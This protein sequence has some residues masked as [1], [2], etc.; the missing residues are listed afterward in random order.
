MGINKMLTQ[1]FVLPDNMNFVDVPAFDYGTP[2]LLMTNDFKPKCP[3]AALGDFIVE[4]EEVLLQASD[5]LVEI[6]MGFLKGFVDRN[7]LTT[8]TACLDDI[9]GII[10][11]IE[12]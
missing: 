9:E 2:Q 8:V 7:N 11:T 6:T 10:K 3:F 4:R 5:A 1:M 12:D